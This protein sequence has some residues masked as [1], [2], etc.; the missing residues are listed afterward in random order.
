MPNITKILMNN[1][2]YII[3]YKPLISFFV[4]IIYLH[5]WYKML[6][7]DIISFY[8]SLKNLVACKQKYLI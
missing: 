2:L 7:I 8:Y 1:I 6:I 3:Y 4:Y 5:Q